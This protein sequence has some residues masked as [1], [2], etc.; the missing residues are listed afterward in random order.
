MLARTGVQCV[1]AYHAHAGGD[2]LHPTHGY[3]LSQGVAFPMFF[4]LFISYIMA[5]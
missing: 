2:S 1:L 5:T 4:K 3:L